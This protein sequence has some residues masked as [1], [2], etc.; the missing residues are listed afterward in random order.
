MNP[1][2]PEIELV[3]RP[4]LAAPREMTGH[5]P[6]YSPRVCH[7]TGQAWEVSNG[8]PKSRIV[9]QPGETRRQEVDGVLRDRGRVLPH[10]EPPAAFA[11]KS[12]GQ[13]AR[14]S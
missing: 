1:I 4:A 3:C 12:Q 7:L 13:F 11:A 10:C 6:S 2:Y 9:A 8:D 14:D 5:S